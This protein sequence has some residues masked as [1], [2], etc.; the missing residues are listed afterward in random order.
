LQAFYMLPFLLSHRYGTPSYEQSGLDLVFRENVV[1]LSAFRPIWPDLHLSALSAGLHPALGALLDTRPVGGRAQLEAHRAQ[2]SLADRRPG[3]AV[4]VLHR[5]WQPAQL[6]RI[7]AGAVC[8]IAGGLWVTRRRAEREAAG[9]V[10]GPG[11]TKG[12]AGAA[13]FYG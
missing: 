8:P 2:R 10:S 7:A 9:K 12:I 3:V 4:P 11:W 5:Q 13:V 1:V 6:L